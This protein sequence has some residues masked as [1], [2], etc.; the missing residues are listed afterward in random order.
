VTYPQVNRWHPLLII[1]SHTIQQVAHHIR[2]TTPTPCSGPSLRM[3]CR[4]GARGVATQGPS[5][6]QS[7][8]IL[9]RFCKLWAINA[10]KVAASTGQWLQVRVWDTTTKGLLW[11]GAGAA[12][13]EYLPARQQGTDPLGIQPP[14]VT[15]HSHVHYG[16]VRPHV[17]WTSVL[18]SYARG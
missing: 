3:S 8:V 18:T 17:Q 13:L 11:V 12:R 7:K 1:P 5:N 4:Q 6:P 16:D 10:H 2:R 9:G 15:L 14:V